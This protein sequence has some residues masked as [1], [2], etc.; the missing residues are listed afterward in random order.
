MHTFLLLP[1]YLRITLAPLVLAH[2]QGLP[3]RPLRDEIASGLAMVAFAILLVEFVLS[4]RFRVISARMG[5]DVTMRLHQLLARTALVFVLIHPFLYG[6]PFNRPMPWD[7]SGQLT[8]GLDAGSLASGVIAWVALPAFVLMS[9]FRDQLPYRYEIWRWFH[10]LGAAAIAVAVTHHTFVAGR[11]SADP[12]LAGFWVLL[13]VVAF[14]SL[15]HTC[16]IAPL[17]ETA[18][19]YHVTS[20]RK[21]ALKTWEL[22]LRPKKGKPLRFD[23]GQ[24]AWLNLGHSAFSLEENPFSISS[25]PSARPD[26][27]F[28]IKEVGDMTRRLGAVAPGERA[29][30]DGPYG[31]LTLE[32]RRGKGIALIAGGVGIAP[33]LSVARQL[34]AEGDHRPVIL[35]YGNR[36]AEQVVYREELTKYADKPNW[37]VIHVLSEPPAGWQGETGQLDRDT[38]SRVF[39]FDGAGEWLYL[40]CGPAPMLDAVEDALTALDVPGEQIVSERFYYD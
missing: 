36:I 39:A 32:G 24:F 14:G 38:L 7:P 28:I 27:Q 19:P 9:I 2:L 22:T 21:I 25:A 33:L 6:T 37:Q 29:F 34:H 3:P 1:L 31:N 15:V 8:L 20:V 4:G 35:L 30:L 13:L 11:Y 10:G 5:M 16:L 23:A 17:R 40:A 12:L 26:I 18:R